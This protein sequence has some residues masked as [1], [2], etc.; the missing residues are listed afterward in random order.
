MLRVM[1]HLACDDEGWGAVG[2]RAG[3]GV[4]GVVYWWMGVAVDVGLFS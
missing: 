2:G 1:V 4:T 3:Y